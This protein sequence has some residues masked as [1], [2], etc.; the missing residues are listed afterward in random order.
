MKQSTKQQNTT[1]TTV[2]NP[3]WPEANQFAIYKCSREVEP[4]TTRNKF[5]AGLE[6]G[7][8]GSQGKCPNHWATLPPGSILVEPMSLESGIQDSGSG[9]HGLR[10]GIRWPPG[11]LYIGQCY[12]PLHLHCGTLQRF[13]VSPGQNLFALASVQPK[14]DKPRDKR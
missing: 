10:S 7:I 6:P 13:Q 12:G 2:K 1:T 3:N 9:I 14:A 4:G 5:R 11:V 8:S